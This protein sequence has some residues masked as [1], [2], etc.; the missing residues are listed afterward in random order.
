MGEALVVPARG[1]AE[2]DMNVTTNLA[3]TLLKFLGRGSDAPGQSVAY[4]LTGKVSLSEGLLRS[5]PF[6]ERGSFR[7]Q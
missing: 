3:G 7:L 6:D 1:E 5:I 2:F 4:R